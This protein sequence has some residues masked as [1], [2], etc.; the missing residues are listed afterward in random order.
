M[1]FHGVKVSSVF[2]VIPANILVLRCVLCDLGI[3]GL[4]SLAKD[5]TGATGL[6]DEGHLSA[7]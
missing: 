2:A 7:L 4:L 3:G 5:E 6:F 1:Q